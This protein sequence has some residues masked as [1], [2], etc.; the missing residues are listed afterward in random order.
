[1][2][3]FISKNHAS[4]LD[5]DS[6][7]D[8]IDNLDARISSPVLNNLV[9]TLNKHYSKVKCADH[10]DA[11]VTVQVDYLGLGEKQLTFKMIGCC[12]DKFEAE[13]QERLGEIKVRE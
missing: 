5:A 6:L 2:L 9:D 13:L 11:A 7:G 3:K 12:C 8:L 1:M 4:V 10:R